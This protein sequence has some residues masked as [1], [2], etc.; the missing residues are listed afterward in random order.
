M[1]KQ[2]FFLSHLITQS[3]TYLIL[4][5]FGIWL[6]GCFAPSEPP[7]NTN[8]DPD[9]KN[10]FIATSST[11][12]PVGGSFQTKNT[13]NNVEDPTTCATLTAG[14][15]ET[16]LIVEYRQDMFESYDTVRLEFKGLNSIPG[17]AFIEK[18]YSY[19]FAQSGQYRITNVADGKKDIDERDETNNAYSDAATGTNK[20][21]DPLNDVT[22][23]VTPN[24][25]FDPIE[26]GFAPGEYVKI[27]EL[28]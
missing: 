22:V 20:R 24:P 13:T 1:S 11:S 21:A 5:G 18:N 17:G 19:V 3:L 7:C 4:I 25:D 15:S 14:N 8:S 16:N 9:L 10:S 12:V 23:T 28:N 27:F 26:A 6:S 2:L